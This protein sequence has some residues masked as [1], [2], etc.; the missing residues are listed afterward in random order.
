MRRVRGIPAGLVALAAL[1]AIAAAGPLL[2]PYDPEAQHREHAFA[3]PTAIHVRDGQGRWHR[4]FVAGRGGEGRV[5]IEMWVTRVEEGL[6]G[7][8]ERHTSLLG[9]A[10]PAHLFLLGTDRFG[11]D[12]WSRLLVGARTS[13]G[14]GAL[15]A[16]LSIG[17][18]VL[19]GGLAGAWGGWIDRVLVHV[20]D[21][22]MAVPW[23]YLLLAIRAAM[24]LDLPPTRT[25]FVLAVLIGCIGWARPARLVRAMVLSGKTR[26]YVDAARGCGGTEWHVLR[27]HLLPPAFALMAT[28][29]AILAPQFT[30][31]EMTLSF[32]GLGP[33][34]PVASWGTL[35][36]DV[37]RDHLLEPSWYA[38]AP[39]VVV[40]A[41]FIVYHW[42]A[43]AVA[44]S[45]RR[46]TA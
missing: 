6:S 22:F 26:G 10:A 30:L 16:S 15:A 7:L 28:Q 45:Q 29:A 2:A 35:L 38:A 8:P 4:P 18:G 1:Y 32:F 27:R 21:V 12:R 20:A 24:P 40:V 43:D 37:A 36:G 42:A 17:L 44:S 3:A 9:V 5:P 11:R 33:G 19:L 31:A 46:A 25:F 34:A 41:V 23:L 13:L 39:A 14:A